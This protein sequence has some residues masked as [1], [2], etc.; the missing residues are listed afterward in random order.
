MRFYFKPF[1][2][3]V[4]ALFFRC[5]EIF[6]D[7]PVWK[8]VPELERREV[9]EDAMVN[10]AKKEKEKA[11]TLRKRNTT[12]LTDILDRM[13]NIKYNTTWTNAKSSL[14]ENPAFADDDELL[15]MDKED[16]LI[17]FEDHIRQLEKEEEVEKEKER[18]RQKRFQRK[19]RDA[20]IEL[21]DELHESGKLTSMSLWVELYQAV[22]PDTRFSNMLGQPGSTPLDLFKFYVEDL[23]SRY[24]MEKKVIKEILKE[25][26]YEVKPNT[27]FEDFA[28]LVCD[29]NRSATL[30]AGNVKLTYN[31]LLEKA[32]SKEKERMKEET[33]KLRKLETSFRTMLAKLPIDPSTPW[34][35]ARPQLEKQP[36]FEAITQE[37]ERARIYKEYMKDLEESCSHSH[38]KRKKKSK[39]SKK[40]RRS[41]SVSSRDSYDDSRSRDKKR[42]NGGKSSKYS[43]SESSDQDSDSERESNRRSK[44]SKKSKRHRSDSDRA[45]SGKYSSLD[46][47]IFP[48]Y[49]SLY[50]F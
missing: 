21:L 15:A 23:K 30:D 6:G 35:T 3:F 50:L 13:T 1:F 43:D 44:K 25:K 14:L 40:H 37:Y 22:C 19:N 48:L 47:M 32:E 39:K 42:K 5:D 49:I 10:L 11:K 8:N 12:R 17:V 27:T 34:E 36:E 16:A 24:T 9:F 4:I 46:N 26:N 28:T 33:R 45:S 7:L 38:N 2:S 18:K 31:S 29:D 41:S 20:F